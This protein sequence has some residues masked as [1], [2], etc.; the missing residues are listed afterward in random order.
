MRSELK[1]WFE[2]VGFF[3][4]FGVCLCVMDEGEEMDDRRD[5]KG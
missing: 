5:M 2:C 1:D 3:F 4:F